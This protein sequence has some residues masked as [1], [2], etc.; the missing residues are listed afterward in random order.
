MKIGQ[1]PDM[2]GFDESLKT[3]VDEYL[4]EIQKE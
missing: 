3:Q 2:E 1:D 4:V